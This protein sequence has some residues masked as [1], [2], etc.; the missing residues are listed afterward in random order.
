MRK[1][2]IAGN[3]KMNL[4]LSEAKKLLSDLQAKLDG[5]DANKVEIGVCPP[6]VYL[7]AIR[8]FLQ[9]SRVPIA[10]GCQNMH[11][12]KS[13]AFTGE[14]SGGMIADIGCSYVIIGHSERRHVFGETDEMVEKKVPAAFA[15]GLLPI[16]CVGE[17]LKQREGQETLAVVKNQV[18]RA[19]AKLTPAQIQA[20]TIAYEPVWAIGTG[21]AATAQMAQEVHKMIRNLLQEKYGQSIADIVRI[22]YGGSVKAKN[23]AELLA[24]PDIDGCLVGGASL[25]SEDFAG[26]VK[27]CCK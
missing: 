7:S 19:L 23:A 21:K 14:I 8:E 18:E 20:T 11:W 24:Q 2:F 12:E 3:W 17:T 4:T 26:I 6:F 5:I 27:A 15:N 22:Q 25:D 10:L 16:V 9:G 1:Y 13:G